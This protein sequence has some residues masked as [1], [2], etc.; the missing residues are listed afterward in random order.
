MFSRGFSCYYAVQTKGETQYCLF[1]RQSFG[2]AHT[3]SFALLLL[4][5]HLLL[6]LV[7]VV[8]HS[9]LLL[10]PRA[11]AISHPVG[12][13]FR[14]AACLIGRPVGRNQTRQKWP[15]DGEGATLEEPYLTS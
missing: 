7:G 11:R 9:L 13:A 1:K 10:F 14:G 6:R 8:L 15:S 3:T 2:M 5:L 12:V 4:L